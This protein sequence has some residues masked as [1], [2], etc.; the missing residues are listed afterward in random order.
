MLLAF[1]GTLRP[2]QSP[3]PQGWRISVILKISALH[4][5]QA[6]RSGVFRGFSFSDPHQ[7]PVNSHIINTLIILHPFHPFTL[8]PRVSRDTLRGCGKSEYEPMIRSGS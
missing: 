4:P 5:I 8:N 3:F 6:T 1:P 7:K 2:A